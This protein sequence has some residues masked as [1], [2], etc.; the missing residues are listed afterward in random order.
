MFKATKHT[1]F[2]AAFAVSMAGS[3]A[4]LHAQSATDVEK[5]R[6]S[7]A[8][9]AQQKVATLVGWQARMPIAPHWPKQPGLTGLGPPT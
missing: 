4:T 2:I 8:A 5:C 6:S 9:S 7:S 1:T 3:V